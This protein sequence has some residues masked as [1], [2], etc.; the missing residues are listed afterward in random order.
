MRTNMF[1]SG[2]RPGF[3]LVEVLIAVV[4]LALGVLGLAAIFPAV[5]AQQRA[6]SDIV[7]S[8]G[9]V[10]IAQAVLAR[11]DSPGALPWAELEEDAIFSVGDGTVD[12]GIGAQD[13]GRQ[14]YFGLW[15]TEW[16]WDS[17]ARDTVADMYRRTG[18]IPVYGGRRCVITRS[19][20][21]TFPNLVPIHL[22]VGSPVPAESLIHV[23]ERVIPSTYSGAT[24]QFVWDVVA[25]RAPGPVARGGPLQGAIFVRRIDP[26]LRLPAGKSLSDV[27]LPKT[28]PTIS[29]PAV[30]PERFPLAV[31]QTGRPVADDGRSDKS[32]A[33][34]V[35]M[36]ARAGTLQTGN[37]SSEVLFSGGVQVQYNL[38]GQAGQLLLDNT[39]QVRRVV[40]PLL[41]EAG[42]I[43]GA[44]VDPAL[45]SAEVQTLR[46]IVYTPQIPSDIVIFTP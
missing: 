23:R 12:D 8:R 25:R 41:D 14:N 10:K 16:N 27:L 18:S 13:C 15:E 44:E 7:Q 46:Q 22:P 34:P 28:A 1:N 37:V 45:S 31:D 17:G 30:R 36:L 9:V 26:N 4:V 5:I 20:N 40:R 19:G 6:A 29:D 32:Y 43:R 3:S 33:H 42:R 2:P 38:A 39:G 35:S 24:P 21:R 11:S